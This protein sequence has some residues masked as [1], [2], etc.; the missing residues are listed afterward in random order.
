MND[1]KATDSADPVIIIE[2]KNNKANG[3]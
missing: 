2:E 1:N 3:D